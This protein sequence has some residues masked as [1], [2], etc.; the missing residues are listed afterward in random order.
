M[1][2][3][4]SAP[5]LTYVCVQLPLTPWGMVAIL[6]CNQTIHD[7]QGRGTEA[8]RLSD[9][10]TSGDSQ[11]RSPDFLLC[12]S[13]TNL[14]ISGPENL[15]LHIL[16][17]LGKIVL[18]IR[19]QQHWGRWVSGTAFSAFAPFTSLSLLTVLTS[20]T[21]AQSRKGPAGIVYPYY[22]SNILWDSLEPSHLLHRGKSTGSICLNHLQ[23]ASHGPLH[24]SRAEDYESCM[25]LRLTQR[26]TQLWCFL[27][28]G[29]FC[30]LV[31]G[32]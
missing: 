25:V 32:M 9:F 28:E 21:G 12:C 16:P 6:D 30:L 19:K 14:S 20:C 29:I 24:R 18:I 17:A 31:P 1:G 5:F 27:N 22:L 11:E 15:T 23:A 2:K 8:Q 26:G 3:E 10:P 13:A 4:S 7:T